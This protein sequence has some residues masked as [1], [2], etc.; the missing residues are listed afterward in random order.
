M[1]S[2]F[3]INVEEAKEIWHNMKKLDGDPEKR[4]KMTCDGKRDSKSLGIKGW[5]GKINGFMLPASG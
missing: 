4:Y 2:L 5:S 3:Q 1:F